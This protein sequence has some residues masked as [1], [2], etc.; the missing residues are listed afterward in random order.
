VTSA[1]SR[2][3]VHNAGFSVQAG[4]TSYDSGAEFSVTGGS[5]HGRL[6]LK[7]SKCF[8]SAARMASSAATTV[9]PES[10]S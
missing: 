1:A 2:R 5:R 4:A 7:F 9:P 10:N 3:S 8:V 6:A